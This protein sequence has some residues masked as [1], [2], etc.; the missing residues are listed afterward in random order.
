MLGTLAVI[1]FWWIGT[2]ASTGST[3]GGAITSLGELAGLVSSFLVC[4]QLLLVGRVPW[5]ER[6]V[7]LD[8][9]VSWHRSLGTSVILLVL[10][11]VA[12]MITGG[13]LLDQLTPWSEFFSILRTQPEMLSAVVG[14]ALFFI[15]GLSSARLLR[16]RLSYEWWFAIHFSIYFGIFLTF[17]HQVAAGTHFVDSQWARTVWT[18]MYV[19]TAAALLTWRVI[20]PL[21]WH[22]SLRLR[23]QHVVPEGGGLTSIWLSGH[24]LERTEAQAGQFF[25]VRFLTRG[26]LGTAHPYSLSIAPTSKNLRFTIAALGDHSSDVSRL[27]PGTRAFLEG[28]FGRFTAENATSGR[29]LLIAG[30]AGIG[31]I[32]SLAEEFARTG[33]DIVIVHRAKSFDALALRREFHNGPTIRYVPLPGS[34]KELGYDPLSPEALAQ[35]VPDVSQRESFVCGPPAMISAVANSLESLGIHPTNIH[36]EELSFS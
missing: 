14:T 34:R 36:H 29:V 31:P 26:H 5:F 32:R 23:I 4:W 18:L 30:G 17:G 35:L 6:A 33:Q 13:M 24:H 25:L 15:V 11:H 3:P 12:L 10:A 21:V 28:P 7:G 2:P 20:L 16:R 27:R 22:R 8:R 9:L 1:G 19:A